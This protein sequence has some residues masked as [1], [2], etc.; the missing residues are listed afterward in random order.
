MIKFITDKRYHI[1]QHFNGW[2]FDERVIMSR[3]CL[4]NSQYYTGYSLLYDY[5]KAIKS[6]RSSPTDYLIYN[7]SYKIPNT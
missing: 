2:N 7:G 3:M 1:I 6:I 4:Y 5:M